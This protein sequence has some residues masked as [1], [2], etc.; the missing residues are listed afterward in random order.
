[1]MKRTP[2]VPS[3]S[4]ALFHTGHLYALCI[5]GGLAAAVAA[6]LLLTCA[7]RNEGLNKARDFSLQGLVSA[8]ENMAENWEKAEFWADQM[9]WQIGAADRA[10][11]PTVLARHQRLWPNVGFSLFDGNANLIS[12]LTSDQTGQNRGRNIADQPALRNMVLKAL[13][14]ETSRDYTVFR[15]FLSLGTAVPVQG[16]EV[17]AIVLSVPLDPLYLRQAKR[18]ASANLAVAL[19]DQ[20][21]KNILGDM[22]TAGHSF[23]QKT[24]A[25][26]GLLPELNSL[27]QRSGLKGG[28]PFL[29]RDKD[30]FAGLELLVNAK[31]APVGLLLASPDYAPPSGYH[32]W[33]VYASLIFGALFALLVF[34]FL[35]YREKRMANAIAADMYGLARDMEAEP[36]N[37]WPPALNS[38]FRKMAESME[39]YQALLE[40][41]LVDSRDSKEEREKSGD[42]CAAQKEAEYQR[43]FD[44]LPIGAFKAAADGRFIKV[45]SAFAYLLGYESPM[46]LVA[47]CGSFHNICLY[48]EGLRNPLGL[49]AEKGAG[50]HVLSL[51]RRD[52]QVRHF[53]VICTAL[54]TETGEDAGVIEGF[55]LDRELEEQLSAA[56]RENLYA[57]QERESLARLLAATCRQTQSYFQPPPPKPQ[58]QDAEQEHGEQPPTPA[59]GEAV[60]QGASSSWPE[61]KVLSGEAERLN[62]E[63][64]PEEEEASRERRKSVLAV[65]AVLNDIYQIAV[66]EAESS[67]PLLVPMEFL[68]FLK[69]LCR[70]ALPTLHS[71]GISLRCEIADNLPLR[72]SGPA[73]VLRHALLRS[74][75]A[76]AAPAEGGWACLNVMQDPNSPASAGAARLLFSVSW[77]QH[78][79]APEDAEGADAVSAQGRVMHTPG[80]GFTIFVA[81]A[82]RDAA[83]QNANNFNSALDLP[84]EQNVIQFLSRKMR[85]DLLDGVFTSRLRSM[86]LVV[87][88]DHLC[89]AADECRTVAWEKT[90]EG[91]VDLGAAREE[92]AAPPTQEQLQ[93]VE[94]RIIERSLE[95]EPAADAPGGELGA[96]DLETGLEETPQPPSFNLLVMDGDSMAEGAS[97]TDPLAKDEIL[98]SERHIAMRS[99]DILLIDASLNNRMLFS[100]YLKDANHRITEAHDGQEGVEAFQRGKFDVIFMDMEMPLMDGYQATRVIRALEADKGLPPTPIVGMTSYA[101]PELRRECMLAG[102]TEFL[103]RPFSKNSLLTLLR[104]FAGLEAEADQGG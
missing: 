33:H 27:L 61:F 74:L 13:D 47:E 63:E 4:P 8:R 49:I 78:D 85:G 7:S 16:K 56:E 22:S 29:L 64:S 97:A 5:L 11:I 65:K 101:L 6:F 57:R 30:F 45:N 43:L 19:L 15:G 50:R 67:P 79:N 103:S 1:M 86:Q 100:M 81:E 44:A 55:L 42:A 73:P 88:L 48:G 104:A 94:I 66:T 35:R 82:D 59:A 84:S 83:P 96:L 71:R 24:S 52:G 18:L 93:N 40:N 91:T 98:E 25:P 75:L 70:Q 89:D 92:E 90:A 26:E 76:V 60:Q 31:G 72:M 102:C 58:A 9:A 41:T 23:D 12:D 2:E 87:P 80:E 37:N 54:T 62:A 99:L 95:V 32:I 28:A 53:A 3:S 20:S 68:L 77:S 69:Q 34:F 39:A 36:Q 51:R 21:G 46:N 38:A 17:R 14:G 10:S